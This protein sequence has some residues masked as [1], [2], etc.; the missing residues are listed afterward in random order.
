MGDKTFRGGVHPEEMKELSCEKPLVP[1]A[2]VG[3][4]VFLTS[5]HIGKPA[6]PVKAEGDRVSKGELLG[7]AAEGLSA[8][9]H[10]SID[11]VVEKITPAGVWLRR[12]EVESV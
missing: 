11:G 4:L 9:I 2:P 5:Q 8:N 12:K 7:Q 6:T 10:A 3:D 1:Y